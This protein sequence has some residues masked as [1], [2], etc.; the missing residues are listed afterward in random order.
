MKEFI[1]I[2][3]PIEHSLSPHLHNWILNKLNIDANY[4]KVRCDKTDLPKI[5]NQIKHGNINGINVTIPFK[6]LVV[7]LLDEIKI[8]NEPNQNEEIINFN[9]SFI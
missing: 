6:E 3:N 5:I 1:V 7:K 9:L 4:R 2:G 8:Y